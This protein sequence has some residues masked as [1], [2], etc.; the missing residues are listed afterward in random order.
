MITN[1]YVFK[2]PQNLS[3]RNKGEHI[4][5]LQNTVCVSLL[6]KQMIPEV[7]SKNK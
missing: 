1:T 4:D 5:C 7:L 3:F 2:T 6:H